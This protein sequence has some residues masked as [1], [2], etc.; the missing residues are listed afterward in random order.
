VHIKVKN[1]NYS[2]KI[3]SKAVHSSGGQSSASHGGGPGSSPGKFMLDFWWTKWHKGK[4]SPSTSV[5]LANYH[6]TDSSTFIMYHP[7]LLQ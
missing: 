1:S 4:F 7:S 6:S 3:K 2:N 5:S